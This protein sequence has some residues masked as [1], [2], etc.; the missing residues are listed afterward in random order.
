MHVPHS[1]LE[2][3]PPNELD[4]GMAGFADVAFELGFADWQQTHFVLS[5]SFF[6]IHVLHSHLLPLPPLAENVADR[7]VGNE[8]AGAAAAGLDDDG[9]AD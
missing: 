4:N 3:A 6:T 1:H 5:A 2:E 9:L 8:G 7:D